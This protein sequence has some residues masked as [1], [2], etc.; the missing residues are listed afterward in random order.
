MSEVENSR[1]LTE[2]AGEWIRSNPIQF[3]SLL[4]RKAGR[5]LSPL[6]LG[7]AGAIRVPI[8]AN[9]LLNLMLSGVYLW[10]LV[11]AAVLLRRRQ[12]R[13]VVVLSAVPLVLIA[14][15]LITFGAT[16]FFIPAYASL[17][18]LG[19]HG[20]AASLNALGVGKD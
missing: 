12:F 15:S 9:T 19:S 7:T 10:V 14:M 16:R 1:Q 18:V 5:I 11:G 6:A 17:T 8:L 4:P 2:R 3:L 20:L 13:E